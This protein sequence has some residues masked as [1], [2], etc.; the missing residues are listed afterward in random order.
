MTVLIIPLLHSLNIATF[1]LLYSATVAEKEV[2]QKVAAMLVSGQTQEMSGLLSTGSHY[3]MITFVSP[4]QSYEK[5]R[6]SH[7]KK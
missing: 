7:G 1:F 3:N 6:L 5:E 4:C 2:A